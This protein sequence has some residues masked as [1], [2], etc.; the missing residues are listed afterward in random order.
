[1]K[2]YYPKEKYSYWY[3]VRC[4]RL[5]N[6]K[7]KRQRRTS[8]NRLFLIGLPCLQPLHDN[9]RVRIKLPWNFRLSFDSIYHIGLFQ[10]ILGQRLF[11]N[12]KT[13]ASRY[14]IA[15]EAKLV[16]SPRLVKA[17]LR[18]KSLLA[19]ARCFDIRNTVSRFH[20]KRAIT[21]YSILPYG[22][23]CEGKK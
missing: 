20:W 6:Q 8:Y 15:V 17:K 16:H 2:D 13:W 5:I 22:I 12:T 11:V 23:M 10:S 1:M 18:N 14:A 4:T 3:S 19:G 9:R 21:P 7:R